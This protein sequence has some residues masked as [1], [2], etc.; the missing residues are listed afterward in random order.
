MCSTQPLQTYNVFSTEEF[1]HVEITQFEER[2]NKLRIATRVNLEKR[3]VPVKEI[4]DTLTSLSPDDDEMHTIFL[5][6]HF[7]DLF[8]APDHSELFGRMNFHWNYLNYPLLDHL[9]QRFNLK[10]IKDEMDAYKADLKKFREK[11]PLKLFCQTQKK[12]VLTSHQ[13]SGK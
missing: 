6:K 9:V 4:A 10:E 3:G 1:V 2:F 12:S 13:I 7:K 5:Y 8:N 11:T